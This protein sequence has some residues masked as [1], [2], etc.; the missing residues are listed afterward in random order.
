MAKAE[1]GYDNSGNHRILVETLYR[2]K[3][4]IKTVPGAKYDAELGRWKF[5]VSY[6]VCY[7]LATA[8]GNTIQVSDEIKEFVG[9][10]YERAEVLAQ[11]KA[12]TGSPTETRGGTLLPLQEVGKQFMLHAGSAI[13]ADDMGA[14][15]TVQVCSLMHDTLDGKPSV[16]L[17]V[18]P[19]SV[20]SSWERHFEQWTTI[21]PFVI[22]GGAA[23]RRKQLTA[24][25]E[26]AET[27]PV[28]L[29]MNWDQLTEHSRVAG[30]GSIRLSEKDRTP[31]E[32]NGRTFE[33]IIADEAH[34]MKSPKTKWTRALWAIDGVH[35][36]AL[37]GTPIEKNP[38]DLWSLLHFVNPDEWPSKGAYVPTY[39]ETIYSPFGPGYIIAGVRHDR[40]DEFYHLID[41]Y[42]IRRTKEEIMGRRI[43]VIP[44][45]RRVEL[46]PK[47]RKMYNDFKE[48]LIARIEEGVVSATNPLTATSRLVQLCSAPLRALPDDK[49]VMIDPSP[50]IA[51]LLDILDDLGDEQV[52]VLSAS[53]QL[54]AL[55]ENALEKRGDIKFDVINGDVTPSARGSIVDRFQDGHIRVLLATTQTMSEGVTLTSA[56][57][58]VFLQRAWS[59]VQNAQAEARINRIGQEATSVTII[60]II[61]DDTIDGNVYDVYGRKL[62]MLDQITRDSLKE[63]L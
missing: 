43:E 25:Y 50:K 32:L 42:F 14:G 45:V 36:I 48:E 26:L 20:K 52:V 27:D 37:T 61:T 19:K 34:R 6:A 44:E 63:L 13:L 29:I 1:I 54:L 33:Y 4:L 16:S 58:M 10:E 2:E 23:T 22:Q 28:A 47:H 51:E 11:I 3:D 12:G 41:R 18:C 57:Y 39:C 17:V 62:E 30:Y 56:R 35:R 31:K 46:P 40:A 53:K 49:Y 9:L 7:Q 8:F 55:A 24:A 38:G 60:D 59:M 5:P 21:T 15:K